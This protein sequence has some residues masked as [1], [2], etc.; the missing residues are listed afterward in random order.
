MV[1]VIGDKIVTVGDSA[2]HVNIY[3]KKLKLMKSFKL[4]EEKEKK[5]RKACPRGIST[6]GVHLFI[7]DKTNKSVTK[8]TIEGQKLQ[9][10]E[11]FS[12]CCG[13]A[14]DT[15]REK[16]Y[17]AHQYA[18]KIQVL[19]LNLSSV[20]EFGTEG[21]KE[22]EF[23][24]PRD[25][26]V[27]RDGTIY[28]SDTGN[29]R[30]QV[31]KADGEYITEFGEDKLSAPAG[32]CVDHDNRVLVVDHG[33]HRVCIFN[34]SGELLES[35]GTNEETT[36]NFKDLIGITVDSDGNIYTADYGGNSLQVFE[37]RYII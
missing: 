28:V 19:D 22:K 9:S 25:V 29:N 14:I 16:V 7:S 37:R 13:I 31:F 24:Q 3:S 35:F 18:H 26:A 34:S 23:K 21:K 11:T 15:E 33:N 32:I 10:S 2:R 17:V 30:I 27:A 4:R 20:L 8:Y 12:G 6:D 36:A 5:K 1:V